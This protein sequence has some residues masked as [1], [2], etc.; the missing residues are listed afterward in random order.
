MAGNPRVDAGQDRNDEASL[1]TESEG[2]GR[3]ELESFR[4]EE[5]GLVSRN[6]SHEREH[7]LVLFSD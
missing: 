4:T 2:L 7:S 5:S 1:Q 3:L 6:V